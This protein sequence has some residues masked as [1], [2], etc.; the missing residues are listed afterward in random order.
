MKTKVIIIGYGTMGQAIAKALSRHKS[1]VEIFTVDKNDKNKK[2]TS[3]IKKSDFVILAVKPQNAEE[4]IEQLRNFKLDHKKTI[5][6]SIMAGFPM[7][8]IAKL[9]G[10]KKIVR[11]MPNLGLLVG[12]GIAAWKKTG[13]SESETNKTK[14]FIDRIT[15]NFEVRDEDTID[16]VTAI[17]GSGPAYFFT[18]ADCLINAS[19]SLGLTEEKSKIL[20]GKTFS[21]GAI[22]GKDA[23]YPALIKKIASKGGTTEAALKIFQKKN[24]NKIVSAAVFSAYKRA[25]EISHK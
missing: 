13:L 6:V 8:K 5:L 24:F 22:L 12:M 15:E 2:K 10:H 9:S 20:V 7:K 17:S 18:L 3:S 14:N 4:A 11:M 25:K 1:L 23:D 19:K 21:A 16:K